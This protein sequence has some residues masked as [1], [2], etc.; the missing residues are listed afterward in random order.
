[1]LTMLIPFA[2]CFFILLMAVGIGLI[3]VNPSDKELE[4][5]EQEEYLR[6]WKEGNV[7]KETKPRKRPYR[8]K[9]RRV[10]R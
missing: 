8:N 10:R 2:F 7:K 5:K 4:D 1:M 3:I 9:N 6:L